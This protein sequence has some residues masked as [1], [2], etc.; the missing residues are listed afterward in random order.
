MCVLCRKR[1]IAFLAAFFVIVGL[2]LPA[3]AFAASDLQIKGQS[4]V[5]MDA[6]TG[7][8]LYSQN[9]DLKWYPASVTKIM[10][11]VLALEAVAE[12]RFGM[13][14]MVPT[15]AEA[16]SM[17]GS[18][19]YLYEGERRTLHEMLIAVAVGSGN[20]A[21]YAVA[22]FIGGS[23]DGFIEKMNQKVETLGMS[24]THFVNPHGLHDTNHYT[25]AGDLAK[26]AYYAQAVPHFLEYTSVYEYQF[27]DDPKP[28]IL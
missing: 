18:Q 3:V 1:F 17:G 20:D 12:G 24:G 26:L 2:L 22:E 10:T 7:E 27:R 14:D 6:A 11:L 25:T 4:C 8:I 13:E 16:A 5:L 9:P 21:S 19:V 28:L 23:Y 15:S